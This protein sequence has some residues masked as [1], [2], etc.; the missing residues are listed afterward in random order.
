LIK[1]F[2]EEAFN[3]RDLAAIDKYHAANLI[4]GS[5]KTSESFKK[6]LGALL[7][8]FPDLHV[9]IVTGPRINLA[10]ELI[11]S[12]HDLFMNGKL[13]IDCKQVGPIIYIKDK[14]IQA[15]PSHTISSSPGYTDVKFI[16]L[17]EAA[18]FPPGQQSEVEAVT[19][20]YRIKSNPH[21]RS[22]VS[23]YYIYNTT[24]IPNEY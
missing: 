20:G 10:E 8:G 19:E 7:S 16:L 1:S 22:S 11:D 15:F 5:G 9:N 6:S 4:D 12:L 21:S 3:I 13:G 17:D 2:V 18:Y 14:V 24:I 23:T